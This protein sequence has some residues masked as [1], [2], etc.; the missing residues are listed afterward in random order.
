MAKYRVVK[1]SFVNNM[2]YGEREIEEGAT[3]EYDGQAGDNLE[4]LDKNAKAVRPA[5]DEESLA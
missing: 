1:P 2:F 5:K 3:V 4:P